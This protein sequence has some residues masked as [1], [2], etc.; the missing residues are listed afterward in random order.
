MKKGKNNKKKL[1]SRERYDHKRPTFSFRNYEELNKR[2]K[3]VKKAEKVSN[4]NI[5]EAGVGL[6]E[7]KI[8]KEQKIRDQAY[9]EGYDKGIE[10]GYEL[11]ES[12]YKVMYPCSGCRKP[13]EL[14]TPE[15]KEA[16]AKYMTEHGWAHAECHKQVNKS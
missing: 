6:F 10:E 14:D 1:P 16:A 11:A 15:E 2:I 13:I 3:E 8:K 12:L 4:T 5:V 9:T 7:V